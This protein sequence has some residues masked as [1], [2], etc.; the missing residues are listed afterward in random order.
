MTRSPASVLIRFFSFARLC[1]QPARFR[2]RVERDNGHRAE[3]LLRDPRIPEVLLLPRHVPFERPAQRCAREGRSRSDRALP[4]MKATA[5]M[6]RGGSF[7]WPRR[8]CLRAGPLRRQRRW[9]V[10]T[11]FSATALVGE[12]CADDR[13]T[14]PSVTGIVIRIS[15]SI[16]RR[17][18]TSSRRIARSRCPPRPHARCGR[19]DARRFPA[20][21]ADQNSPRG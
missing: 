12:D 13:P 17:N 16:S 9:L 2:Y 18:A 15:F 4:F 11:G 19:C 7:G 10:S 5:P 20:R 21:S 8:P 6:P 14:R 1:R 3:F